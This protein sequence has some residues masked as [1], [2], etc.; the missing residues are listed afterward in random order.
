MPLHRL[1]R[2]ES[3]RCPALRRWRAT[4]ATLPRGRRPPPSPP[5][6]PGLRWRRATAAED[7]PPVPISDGVGQPLRSGPALRWRRATLVMRTPL[8]RRFH[9]AKGSRSSSVSGY[10]CISDSASRRCTIPI[11]VGVGWPLR[12]Q[13]S[14]WGSRSSSVSGYR[15]DVRAPSVIPS[16]VSGPD[17]QRRRAAVVASGVS[18]RR[19]RRLLDVPRFI[20]VGQPLRCHARATLAAGAAR[21]GLRGAGQPP[22][23]A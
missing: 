13:S 10:R 6:R 18:V 19:R 3:S 4:A 1:R 14:T 15:C 9:L 22:P 23:L 2:R 12:R 16:S 8:C 7:H 20:G 5:P 11:F 17:L 21:P